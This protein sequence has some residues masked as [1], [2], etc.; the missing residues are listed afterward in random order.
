MEKGE[1]RQLNTKK[2]LK[3]K[4]KK[5]ETKKNTIRREI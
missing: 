4:W 3:Y 5:E 2:V 1:Y